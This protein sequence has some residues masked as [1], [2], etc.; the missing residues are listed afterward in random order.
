MMELAVEIELVEVHVTIRFAK[1][2]GII[3]I[4]LNLSRGE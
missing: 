2:I 4:G 1:D 3:G